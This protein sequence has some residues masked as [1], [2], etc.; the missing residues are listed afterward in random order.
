MHH[1]PDASPRPASESDEG[2]EELPTSPIDSKGMSLLSLEIFVARDGDGSAEKRLLHTG[3]RPLRMGL[4]RVVDDST[5][6]GWSDEEQTAV[7]EIEIE[8]METTP[9]PARSLSAAE[10]ARAFW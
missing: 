7:L 9:P 6:G 8:V 3:G 2:L 10:R 1:L 5:E 4:R